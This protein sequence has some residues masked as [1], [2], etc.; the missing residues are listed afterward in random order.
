MFIRFSKGDFN[1]EQK[2]LYRKCVFVGNSL[3]MEYGDSIVG[4]AQL[5]E[6]T[7]KCLDYDVVVAKNSPLGGKVIARYIKD[8]IGK[9]NKFSESPSTKRRKYCV[10]EI[11]CV[12]L[13]VV[14]KISFIRK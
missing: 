2:R 3:V 14:A 4:I 1:E 11:E 13:P 10:E 6:E 9:S 5:H 7:P 8:M 12:S